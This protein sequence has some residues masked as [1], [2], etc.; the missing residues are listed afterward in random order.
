VIV[1]GLTGAIEY[2]RH[3]GVHPTSIFNLNLALPAQLF[4]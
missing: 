4:S 3:D 1:I 2:V